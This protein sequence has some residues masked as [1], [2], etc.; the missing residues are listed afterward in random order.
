[1]FCDVH[2]IVVVLQD[3]QAVVVRRT[4][5]DGAGAPLHDG[6]RQNIQPGQG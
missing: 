6:P 4:D 3:G 1:M 2:A 5:G